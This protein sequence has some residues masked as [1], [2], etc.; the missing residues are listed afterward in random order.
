MPSQYLPPNTKIVPFD[1]DER[2]FGPT[3]PVNMLLF[4]VFDMPFATRSMLERAYHRRD[5][6]IIN[7]NHWAPI[8]FSLP[9]EQV[10]Q[11]PQKRTWKPERL[12]IVGTSTPNGAIVPVKDIV[13]VT[14]RKQKA[15]T[16]ERLT[17]KN[18]DGSQHRVDFPIVRNL[19]QHGLP[20]LENVVVPTK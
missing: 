16:I 9:P 12:K 19:R 4:G 15:Y 1:P 5:L 6:E 20:T 2:L 11:N 17:L 8:Q 3:G 7:S 13:I 18:S 14:Y 10:P